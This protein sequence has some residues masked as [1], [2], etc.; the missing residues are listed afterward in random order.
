MKT[1]MAAFLS[2][3]PFASYHDKF[4]FY[5]VDA[6]STYEGC[7]EPNNDERTV[8]ET[9]FGNGTTVSGSHDKAKEYTLKVSGLSEN[10]LDNYITIVMM[11][12]T[13]HAGTCYMYRPTQTYGYDGQGY[14]VCYFPIGAS[15][16][17]LK[18][19]LTHEANGHGFGKLADEYAASGASISHTLEEYNQGRSYGFYSNVDTHSNITETLWSEFNVEPYITREGIGA[20]EG[21]FTNDTGF[22][23]PTQN[24]IMNK[25]VGGFNAPSRQTL[26]IRINKLLNPSWTYD[27]DVFVSWDAKNIPTAPIPLSVHSLSRGANSKNEPIVDELEPFAPP[28]IVK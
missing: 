22:Y 6:V 1:G 21:A 25:N 27:H 3:E 12:S 16:E 11:N 9:Y 26:Y 18:E 4:N 13:K 10:Q 2:E 20:Y 28:V 14:A 17:A 23:R 24:S 7:L 5:Y 8:F 19:V 15:Y